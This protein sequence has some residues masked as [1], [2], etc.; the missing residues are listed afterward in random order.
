MIPMRYLMW[1]SYLAQ[2]TV[3]AYLSHVGHALGGGKGRLHHHEEEARDPLRSLH[4]RQEHRAAY[5]GQVGPMLFK[6]LVRLSEP[7]GHEEVHR[8]LHAPWK[9]SSDKKKKNDG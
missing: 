4:G 3:L 9:E 7:R 2:Y 8:S 6:V 5:E 1:V